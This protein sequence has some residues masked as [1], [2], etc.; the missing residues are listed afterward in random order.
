M[1]LLL[2]KMLALNKIVNASKLDTS[3]NHNIELAPGINITSGHIHE[4][5][6]TSNFL[7]AIMLASKT[8][9]PV[10]WIH[11]DNSIPFPD[12]IGSFISPNRLILVKISNVHELLW[13]IE[14]ALQTETDLLIVGNVKTMP[15]FTSLIR[16]KLLIRKKHLQEKKTLPTVLILTKKACRLSG[17]ESR[18]YCTPMRITSELNSIKINNQWQL[19][20]EY[21]K[22]SVEKTWILYELESQE[23]YL[24]F[25]KNKKKLIITTKLETQR[26]I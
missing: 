5:Y 7:I 4:I 14:E 22:S 11:E 8:K 19:T 17:I 25:F 18:W 21:S 26:T 6:G 15:N 16:L 20:R 12:G 3:P 13:V 24:D 23:N 2:E 1:E 10:L 9:N